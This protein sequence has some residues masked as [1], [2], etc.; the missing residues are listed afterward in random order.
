MRH[1]VFLLRPPSFVYRVLYLHSQWCDLT[2][3]EFYCC[4]RG[5]RELPSFVDFVFEHV[6]QFRLVGLRRFMIPIGE[7]C[8]DVGDAAGVGYRVER[9]GRAPGYAFGEIR[10]KGVEGQEG[11]EVVTGPKL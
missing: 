2:P 4:I 1:S 3:W 7:G 9:E 10:P 11:S 6:Y 5:E 8:L